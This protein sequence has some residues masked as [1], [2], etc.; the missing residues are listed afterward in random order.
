MGYSDRQI[1][2]LEET[3]NRVPCD[4]VIIGTP[5]NLKRVVKLKKPAV[6]VFYELEEI[7]T[8]DLKSILSEF[9]TTLKASKGVGRR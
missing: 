6:R 1:K 5:I 2:D 8:P 9:V 7:G 4:T 3:I